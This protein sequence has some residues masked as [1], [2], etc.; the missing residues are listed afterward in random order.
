MPTT[1]CVP[2]LRVDGEFERPVDLTFDAPRMSSDG[3]LLLLKLLD[4]RRG[5]TRALAES[6]D[7]QRDQSKVSHSML[8]LIRQR[9]FQI[10]LGYEDANDATALR[11]D[12]LLQVACGR[13]AEDGAIASQPT[14]SRLETRASA[15]DAVRAQRAHEERWVAGLPADLT[16][17]V[18]DIDSTEDPTHGQQQFAFYNTHYGHNIYSPLMIFDQFGALAS[19]R[20]RSGKD[21]S[22][23]FAAPMLE[24]LIRAVRKRLPRVRILVRGDA[25][26]GVARVI[27]RLEFLRVML[28]PV[29]YV[30]GVS[31][32]AAVRRCAASAKAQVERE[33]AASRDGEA[34]TYENWRY[35]AEGWPVPRRLVVKVSRL[36][37]TTDIRAAVTTLGKWMTPEMVYTRLYSPRGDME[38]RIKD[39]KLA[40][41]ADRLSCSGFMANAL[42]LQLHAAAYTLCHELR[43]KAVA[44][45][46]AAS[47]ARSDP[48]Q[49][50]RLPRPQIDIFRLRLLRVAAAVRRSARRI[51]IALPQSFPRA[52]LFRALA[53]ALS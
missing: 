31:P 11:H 35:A 28:G 4:D 24:R 49:Y 10:A 52:E 41:S 42:R 3:G 5:V 30:L 26:F 29:D 47:T 48:D 43:A 16:T 33:A 25:A 37:S 44:I 36:G 46:W 14:F 15:R 2:S 6:L 22:A 9:V 45:E 7:D 8:A 34:R 19:S 12:P 53:A 40:I 18:L 39:F 17:L 51:W 20:L 13:R 21:H 23:Q 1:V 50:R 32:N 38:N 27:R